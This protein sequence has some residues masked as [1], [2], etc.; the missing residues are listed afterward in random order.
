MATIP[1]TS[2]NDTLDGTSGAD[3]ITGEAGDD[4]I[5]GLGGNDDIDGGADNDTISGGAGA[6]T[7]DGGDGLDV[8]DFTASDAAVDADLGA[9][10]GNFGGHSTGDVYLNIEGV[11]GSDFDDRVEGDDQPDSALPGGYVETLHGGDGNDTLVGEG[12]DDSL[13]GQA[14]N[15][16][17]DGGMGDDTV[18]G[19]AGDDLII[20]VGGGDDVLMGGADNDTIFGG[21]GSDTIDGGDGLDV[22]NYSNSDAGIS[23]DLGAGTAGVGS[24]TGGD[25]DGDALRS[26][27]GAVGSDFDDDIRGRDQVLSS[28]PGGYI[29][30]LQGGDGNDTIRG[31]EGDDSILGQDGNDVVDAGFDDD[32]VDGGAGND[33][34]LGRPGDDVLMGGADNDTIS[35]DEDD[36][37]IT[38]GS[39]ADVFNIDS[40]FGNDLYLDFT[41]GEDVFDASDIPTVAKAPVDRPVIPGEVVVTNNPPS[42]EFPSGSQTL[43]FPDGSSA[44]VPAGTIRTDTR[45]NRIEDLV[46]A[47]IT[48][49]ARGT[50]IATLKGEK[51]VEQLRVGDKVI[52]RDIGATPIKW[53]GR[54]TVPAVGNL[55][56]IMIEAGALG[57]HTDLIVS[58]QHRMFLSDA[59]AE[60]FFG[61]NHVLIPAKHMVNGSSIYRLEG[62]KVEYWHMMFDTHQIVYSNGTM[63][64]SFHPGEQAMSMLDEGAREE[65]LSIFPDLKEEQAIGYG[66]T[67]A[68]VLNKHEASVLM[69]AIAKTNSRV[70]S[71]LGVPIQ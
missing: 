27:E 51:P 32:T 57:N 9:S 69:S 48:C 30:T 24:G 5:S 28:L 47:G 8:V 14:G 1:G 66:P 10:G 52:T 2:G 31:N 12:G 56:P 20:D 44:T 36:D 37:T 13:L 3:T 59:N 17:L 45:G 43:T 67:V 26:I 58:P 39:G 63:S 64:E 18:D 40:N 41:L 22:V 46:E 29:E 4:V 11:I 42:A 7:I 61:E 6:D 23:V 16:G 34:I 54:R 53:I 68:M 19:G 55:A 71:K 21:A 49:F 70:Q 33:F 60:L 25:A 50:L 35:G 15:D 62:G 65:I 38:G